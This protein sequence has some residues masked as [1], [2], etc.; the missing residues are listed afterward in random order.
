MDSTTERC[1]WSELLARECAHCL[2]HGD[3]DYDSLTDDE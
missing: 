1:T 3:I 2:G